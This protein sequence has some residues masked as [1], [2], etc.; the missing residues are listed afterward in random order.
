MWRTQIKNQGFE[1]GI[2]FEIILKKCFH[3]LIGC[4]GYLNMGLLGLDLLILVLG[5]FDKFIGIWFSRIGDTNWSGTQKLLWEFTIP[6]RNFS[7]DWGIPNW[8][9]LKIII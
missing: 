4:G 8:V 5:I 3:L 2:V 9:Q 1:A 7:D 6:I